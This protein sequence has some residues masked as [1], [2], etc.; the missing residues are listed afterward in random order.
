M[1]TKNNKK[2][3]MKASSLKM[4]L[5]LLIPIVLSCNGQEKDNTVNLAYEMRMSGQADTAQLILEEFLAND[6]TSAL[7]W[8][9][10]CRIHQHL[11]KGNPQ[12]MMESQEKSLYCI[13]QAI[14]HDPEN[15]LYQIKMAEIESLNIYISLNMGDENVSE[16]LEKVE[17]IYL[18]AL[19]CDPEQYHVYLSLV[20]FFYSLPE[21]MGG[22]PS[23]A[24]IYAKKLEEK[25][26]VLGAKA[27]EVFL[28]EDADYVAYWEK[29]LQDQPEN[30]EVKEALGKACM[31]MGNIERAKIL[32][33]EIITQEPA[34]NILHLSIGRYY[35]MQAMQNP[36]SL[37]SFAPS[38]ETA[39]QNYLDSQPEP[40]NS[41]KAWVKGTLAKIKFRMGDESGAEQLMAEANT[42]D[43]FHSK[44]LGVP[45][46]GLYIKPGESE[47]STGYYFRPF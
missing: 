23:K 11:G 47:Y 3:K 17:G 46:Q 37:G 38:V 24:N 30:T 35:L 32:F 6:S 19:E 18:K 16:P 9:E 26:A 2:I 15:A 39:F 25:D 1:K 14:K 22:D 4:F 28:P 34:K 7:A 42:L 31:Y 36:D 33:D 44:A 8:F 29:I 41:M 13:T 43:K 10:L 45:G 40:N 5:L 21:E 12:S 20:E 27:R